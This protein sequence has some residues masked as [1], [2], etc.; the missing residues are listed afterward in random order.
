MLLT[1]RLKE[2]TAAT[3]FKSSSSC[4]GASVLPPAPN[5]KP[6][7][8][9][10]LKEP[11]EDI[12]G[13]RSPSGSA[14]KENRSR[15]EPIKQALSF[16]FT[17]THWNKNGF[18]TRRAQSSHSSVLWT[19]GQTAHKGRGGGGLRRRDRKAA[20]RGQSCYSRPSNS[21]PTQL[22]SRG[23]SP[24]TLILSSSLLC[25]EWDLHMAEASVSSTDCGPSGSRMARQGQDP[26]P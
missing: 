17:A 18:K 6:L 19:K 1:S 15:Q 13:S 11:L 22:N 25:P 23:L 7:L 20:E 21:D 8:S 16:P 12:H 14:L 9:H 2:A 26:L 4:S 10:M 5:V 3:D 24:L